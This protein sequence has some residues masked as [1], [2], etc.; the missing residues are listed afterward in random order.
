MFTLPLFPLDAVLFPG[1]PIQLHV[2]E[3]RYKKMIEKCLSSNREF[4]VVLI[5][6]GVEALGP[7]PEP[8]R[9][10]CV[11]RIT[12]VV[13]LDEGRYNIYIVGQERFRIHSVD[14]HSEPYLIGQVEPYPLLVTDLDHLQE[15]IHHIRPRLK[16]YIELLMQVMGTQGEP[17]PLPEM[18]E[19]LAYMAAILLRVPNDEKQ[20]FLEIQGA[21]ELFQNLESVLDRELALLRAMLGESSRSGIGV[22]S[23]N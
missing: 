6:S 19:L 22:F 18:A 23:R 11:A 4:G 17:E 9:I 12:S 14:R 2:F 13:P 8:C 1:M 15:P 7:L 5:R 20:A 21:D 16:R 10:G 3:P